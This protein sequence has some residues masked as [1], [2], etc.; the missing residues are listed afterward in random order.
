[1]KL[2]LS[3]AAGLCALSILAGPS[4]AQKKPAKPSSA[5]GRQAYPKQEN[6]FV[7]VDEFVKSHRPAGTAVSLEGYAVLAYRAGDG[8][9]RVYIVDSVD[10]VLNAKDANGEAAAGA[11]AVIP[12]SAI[13]SNAS[14]NKGWMKL[15]MFTG[16]GTA[17]RQ[18]R[19]VAPRIRVTGWTASGRATISPVTKIEVTNENGEFGSLR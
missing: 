6:Q 13:R 18:L 12:A 10:H 2:V 15:P 16:S 4:I 9:V 19:D 7:V 14:W 1:M 3:S 11:A 8:G 17:Q 5:A